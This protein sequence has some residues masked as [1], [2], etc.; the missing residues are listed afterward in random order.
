[1]SESDLTQ[2]DAHKPAGYPARRCRWRAKERP[3]KRGPPPRR[4]RP[5][6][7]RAAVPIKANTRTDRHLCM[8]WRGTARRRSVV[9]TGSQE[10]RGRR[11][12]CTPGRT[13]A[14]EEFE[15]PAAARRC[16][17]PRLGTLLFAWLAEQGAAGAATSDFRHQSAPAPVRLRMPRTAAS[18]PASSS[19]RPSRAA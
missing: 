8:T 6:W 13:G 9:A 11:A 15:V 14:G 5:A 17:S 16:S 18:R 7:P 2:V 3:S 10:S 12:V 1:M 4:L 19:P